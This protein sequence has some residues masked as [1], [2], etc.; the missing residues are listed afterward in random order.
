[1]ELVETRSPLSK[2]ESMRKTVMADKGPAPAGPYSHAVVANGF[3]FI[4]GQGPVN[5]ETGA[6]PDA[7]ADQ[8]RQ[9]FQ[10]VQTILEAAGSSLD[11][12]VKVN[13]YVTD[14][15]RFAEFNEVYKE[16]FQDDPP[17]RTTVATALLGILV[18]VDCIAAIS[19]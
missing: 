19:E 8:V 16:F 18:E 7:F 17:A 5:P 1:V 13:A 14:L 11:D 10:N 15:T 3:V 12:V 4:S 2:E 6:M 9:T